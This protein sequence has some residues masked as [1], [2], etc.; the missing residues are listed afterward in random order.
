MLSTNLDHLISAFRGRRDARGGLEQAR[1]LAVDAATYLA[2]MRARFRDELGDSDEEPIFVFSAGWR[3]GSTLVQR[4][5]MADGSTI[6]WGEPYA[7]SNPVIGM[8]D[9]F[10]PFDEDWPPDR[11]LAGSGQGELA[12]SWVANMYPRVGQ[13]VAAHRAYF[14]KLFKEPAV[15]AGHSRWGLKEVRLGT[16]EAAYLKLLFPKAKFLFVFR[17]PLHAF[18]SFWSFIHFDDYRVWPAEPV[19][20]PAAYGRVWARMVEDFVANHEAVGGFLFRF[21]DLVND[22][23]VIDGLRR[24]LNRDLPTPEDV[25]V[26]A[27]PRDDTAENR[28]R[29]R[30][31]RYLPKLHGRIVARVV[32]STANKVGYTL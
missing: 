30:R 31:K 26:I 19:I 1:E 21:E 6:I 8:A 12:D 7:R 32:R 14:L 29:E 17:H 28:M 24:Y 11:F 22:P 2:A 4:L 5:L 10:R 20:T 15:A 23:A 27:R 9:Q 18:A 25:R 3:S 16:R 13:L